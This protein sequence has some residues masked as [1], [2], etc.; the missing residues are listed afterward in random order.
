MEQP[1]CTLLALKGF[2]D[3]GVCWSR[4][5]NQA[6]VIFYLYQ[7]TFDW[8]LTPK[9]FV[10]A[11]SK[12]KMWSA[13]CFTVEV[14]NLRSNFA[15]MRSPAVHSREQLRGIAWKG[16]CFLS[17]SIGT[18]SMYLARILFLDC[19]TTGSILKTCSPCPF[20]TSPYLISI[21]LARPTDLPATFQ[22]KQLMKKRSLFT[23]VHQ[24]SLMR[25]MA[26]ARLL[27]SG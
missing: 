4:A 16:F 17:I 23:E 12:W 20:C 8:W 3:A 9:R 25:P 21:W 7:D 19:F 26:S 22:A 1:G 10:F 18:P 2:L 15:L 11:K 6:T 13:K 14:T 27:A 5:H 24:Q